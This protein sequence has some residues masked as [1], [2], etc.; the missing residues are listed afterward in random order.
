L[1]TEAV[2]VALET[3]SYLPALKDGHTVRQLVQQ[4]F[5]FDFAPPANP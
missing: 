4:R 2:R 1:F 3:A 5:Q